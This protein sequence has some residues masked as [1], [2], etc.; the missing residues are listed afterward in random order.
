MHFLKFQNEKKQAVQDCSKAIELDET[1][2]KAILRRA[3]L[4][5]E[6]DSLDESLADF[7]K[8]LEFDPGNSEARAALVVSYLLLFLFQDLQI[9]IEFAIFYFFV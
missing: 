2:L 8:V 4:H 1:Y 9:I 3:R 7:K 6:V 5:E